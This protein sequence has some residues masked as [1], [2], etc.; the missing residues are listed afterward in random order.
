MRALQ[1]ARC[2][3]RRATAPRAP[4]P[5]LAQDWLSHAVL[6]V[7]D[8]EPLPEGSPLLA[9][10][11]HLRER[12]HITPHVAAHTEAQFAATLFASNLERYMR[13]EPLQN[14]VDWD[15]GY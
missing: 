2:C 1:E 4:H 13:G 6:D 11:P 10:P 5:S 7:F 14:V 15:K 8:T 12:L 9:L 3:G